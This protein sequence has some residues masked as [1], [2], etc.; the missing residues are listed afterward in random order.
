V[1]TLDGY[2]VQVAATAAEA[3]GSVQQERPDAILLDLSM[4]F[5]NGVGFLHRLRQDPANRDIAVAVITGL[6]ALDDATVTEAYP[7]H[8]RH[9][10]RRDLRGG[11]CCDPSVADQPD[12]GTR[13]TLNFLTTL[14]RLFRTPPHLKGDDR[15]TG[16]SRRS[17]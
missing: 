9:H 5:I 11:R 14:R 16:P 17:H 13:G 8:G 12:E 1:L 15:I 3:L 7:D 10:R 6:P 4:P 2:R